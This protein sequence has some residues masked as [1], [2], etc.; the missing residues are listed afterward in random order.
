MGGLFQFFQRTDAKLDVTGQFATG[1][2]NSLEEACGRGF[3][4]RAAEKSSS[5]RENLRAKATFLS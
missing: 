2:W 1:P 4:L 5:N 3:P